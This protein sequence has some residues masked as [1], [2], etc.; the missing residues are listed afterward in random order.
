[1]KKEFFQFILKLT[2]EIVLDSSNAVSI[3]TQ[4]IR[5]LNNEIEIILFLQK[6]I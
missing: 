4:Q 2:Y 6:H 5:L 3:R 1:M